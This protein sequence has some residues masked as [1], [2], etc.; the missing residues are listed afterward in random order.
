MTSDY[1]LGP[2]NN[3]VINKACNVNTALI[4]RNVDLKVYK[5]M[6]DPGLFKMGF[7]FST[8]IEFQFELNEKKA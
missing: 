4:G 7:K 2:I 8:T 6:A 3:L 5:S 1:V